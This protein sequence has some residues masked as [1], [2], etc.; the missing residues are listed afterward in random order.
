MMTIHYDEVYKVDTFVRN[1]EFQAN[2]TNKPLKSDPFDSSERITTTLLNLS[3]I[4]LLLDTYL[5]KALFTEQFI[6]VCYYFI[7]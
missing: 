1:I 4:D 2:K 5:P 3:S 7:E 6:E